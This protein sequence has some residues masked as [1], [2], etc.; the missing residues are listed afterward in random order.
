MISVAEASA[1]V[2]QQN[3]KLE[4]VYVPLIDALNRVLAED[5]VA[6]RNLPPFDKVAMDG[7]GIRFQDWQSG[8][9]SF[10]IVGT[11]FAG[12]AALEVET[13][14][15]C[16]EIM[17]GAPLP[18]FYDTVIRYEDVIINA[19]TGIAKVADIEVLSAQNVQSTGNDKKQGEIVLKKNSVIGAAEIA[20]LASVGRIEVPV[21]QFPKVAIIAT[22]DEL[23]PVDTVP[24]PYQI[25]MSNVWAIAAALSKLKIEYQQF[26]LNDDPEVLT[27]KLKEI[28]GEFP[29]IM[30]SGGVSKGKAD[31]IPDILTALGVEKLFHRVAQ[32]PGK[33]FWFGK[34]TDS[35]LFFA[36]P[37][38]PV[39]TFLCFYKYFVPWY[40]QITGRKSK[41]ISAHMAED[42]EFNPRLTYFL[43]VST[44]YDGATLMARP[45]SGM[46]SGDFANL[47][48]V[49]A[50]IELPAEQSI[51]KKGEVYPLLTFG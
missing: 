38:N 13:V 28:M 41:S 44:Y 31:H 37:G 49:D 8:Q 11:Q 7:I 47:A 23:V 3:I 33:P 14:G 35:H 29:V 15:S 42:F 1:I 21:L 10:P 4:T 32:K 30:L 45:M 24:L 6:D 39:S 25:R 22:G 17:T 18:T 26:H 2:N 36:F 27:V 43:Q 48:H 9:R 20:I 46:G 5:I 19:E 12:M 51:F 34:K 50:F 16:I 40:E